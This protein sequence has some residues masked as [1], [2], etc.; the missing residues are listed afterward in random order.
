MAPG[1]KHNT[2][3]TRKHTH[4]RSIQ[5]C[6]LARIRHLFFFCFILFSLFSL[7]YIYSYHHPHLNFFLSLNSTTPRAIHLHT[8][9]SLS[10]K[11]T[12]TVSCGVALSS[13]LWHFS[14]PYFHHFHHFYYFLILLF[15]SISSF[16]SFSP[17]FSLC[18]AILLV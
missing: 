3:C 4:T 13:L 5:G 14:H 16:S 18:K 7:C 6:L 9:L 10:I 1:V 17:R 11:S 2:R 12:S 8:L 15:L